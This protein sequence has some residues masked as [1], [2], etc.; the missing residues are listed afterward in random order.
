MPLER[1]E[2]IEFS[3]MNDKYK[4]LNGQRAEG[5]CHWLLEA[6]DFRDWKAEIP[7]G[8]NTKPRVLLLTGKPG[9]GKSVLMR[10]A[11]ENEINNEASNHVVVYFWFDGESNQGDLSNSGAG[12]FRAMLYQLLASLHLDIEALIKLDKA[13]SETMDRSL[14]ASDVRNAILLTLSHIPAADIT[15]FLDGLDDCIVGSRC[16]AEPIDVAA[17][18]QKSDVLSVLEFL[19]D[20]PSKADLGVRL[21]LS[22][23]SP[24]FLGDTV[25]PTY[26]IPVDERNSNDI[27]TYLQGKLTGEEMMD[28]PR[29]RH[30]LLLRVKWKASGTFLWVRLVV[31][32]IE[33][34]MTSSSVQEIISL[35]KSEPR[36]LYQLYESLLSHV[37]KNDRA[38]IQKEAE[39][40]IHLVQVAVR[41]LTVEE[42]GSLLT[43]AA[44]GQN[45]YKS[46]ESHIAK[47][48]CGL[49][50]CQL[51][52]S[53]PK[54]PRQVIRFIH[55]SVADFV[56]GQQNTLLSNPESP[57][58][59]QA[60]FHLQAFQICAKVIQWKLDNGSKAEPAMLP[61]A[62]QFWMLHARKAEAAMVDHPAEEYENFILRCGKGSMKA[63][64]WYKES[65]RSGR[66]AYLALPS[67]D[68]PNAA[69]IRKL[70]CLKVPY[71]LLVLLA[72]E[73]CTRLVSLHLQ[74]E[75]DR[76]CGPYADAATALPVLR[77]AVF[78]A[79]LRGYDATVRVLLDAADR[80]GSGMTAA[81]A[82][83]A[84][85]EGRE[86]A[87]TAAVIRG[88]E[89]V[90]ELLMER[91]ADAGLAH[92]G[93]DY[94][95]LPLHVAASH[96][97]V[98]MVHKLLKPPRKK[99]PGRPSV[100][101]LRQQPSPA[102]H[103]RKVEALLTQGNPDDLNA[104]HVAVHCGA[105]DVLEKLLECADDA[106]IPL[107]P[108][109][110]R[111]ASCGISPYELCQVK[112]DEA[113]EVAEVDKFA[114][115]LGVMEENLPEGWEEEDGLRDDGSEDKDFGDGGFEMSCSMESREA[116]AMQP[117]SERGL[118]LP[119]CT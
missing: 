58:A 54:K 79:A 75:C 70:D 99:R 12:F 5:T 92:L 81:A 2:G 104:L 52:T 109:L 105:G 100:D 89:R 49:V 57:E 29:L 97:D 16:R 28:K 33:Q 1:L 25:K 45:T 62:T 20:L 106:G 60:R 61:Y 55:E 76:C 9:C 19:R 10:A 34:K 78:L 83:N 24:T 26:T 95:K 117:A 65:F 113:D 21:C 7:K 87:L 115:M 85:Y 17:R 103:S 110:A 108:L 90:V 6:D 37:D 3:R 119:I 66:A 22:A 35:I 118:P 56:L 42:V 88:H 77:Q 80:A 36:D 27:W 59:A 102:Q 111:R 67:A 84:H 31:A 51:D 14:A 101:A 32:Q 82:I 74:G 71:C 38:T 98:N 43:F 86:T 15:I 72:F 68:V 112:M 23:R 4:R 48:S 73:G 41:G 13:L 11:V 18:E 30:R 91:G 39:V 8:E 40:L 53:D 47:V 63:A 96:A 64:K 69:F 50:E 94:H 93:P 107:Q 114:Y 116:S 46:L 44:G